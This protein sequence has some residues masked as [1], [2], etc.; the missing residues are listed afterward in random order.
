[1]RPRALLITPIAVLAVFFGLLARDI[2]AQSS[3]RALQPLDAKGTVTYFIS[4]GLTGSEYL[5]GDKELAVWALRAWE[6]SLGGAI[7]FEPASEENALVQVHW[8]PASDGLYGEMRPVL[9]NG[10]RGAAVYVRPDTRALGRV[11]SERAARDP[12]FRDTIVYLTCVH[13]LGHALG[14]EHTDDFRD[15]MYFFGYGGDIPEFFGRYRSQ[16]S[17]RAGIANASGLSEG[18]IARVRALYPR[19]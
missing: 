12:L 1:M 19:K 16:I 14:L 2:N 3:M 15:I 6:K 13:E 17:A 10:K 4:E 9:V 18:D 7:R 5:V 11:L 8:V